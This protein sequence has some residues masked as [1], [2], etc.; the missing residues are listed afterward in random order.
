M[1]ALSDVDRIFQQGFRSLKILLN[2]VTMQDDSF[3]CHCICLLFQLARTSHALPSLLDLSDNKICKLAIL[4]VT[5]RP[6]FI[7]SNAVFLNQNGA[8]I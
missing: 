7:F 5:Q 6:L 8:E 3:K 2:I 4:V 1:K